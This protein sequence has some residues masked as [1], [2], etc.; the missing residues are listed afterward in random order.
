MKFTF[1]FPEQSYIKGRF[2]CKSFFAVE[3]PTI[4]KLNSLTPENI[5]REFFDERIEKINFKTKTDL[6]II[7]IN[8]FTAY[9]GYQIAKEFRKRGNKVVIGGLH[10]T[11]CPEEAEKY[12][13]RLKTA[14]MNTIAVGL[15]Y[16]GVA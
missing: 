4:A 2:W 1:V 9:R 6:V 8:T 5:E 13:I 7:T 15:R 16:S 3:P 12:E 10:A 11:L 14:A